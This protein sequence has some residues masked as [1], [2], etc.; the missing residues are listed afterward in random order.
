[1]NK[2]RYLIAFDMDGT[3]LEDKNKTILPLTKKYLKKLSKEGHIIVLASGRPKSEL[4]PYYNELELSSPLV[5]F[6]GIFC[7]NPKDKNFPTIKKTFPKEWA[8]D[9]V[10]QI[11]PNICGNIFI[12][13]DEDIWML[14]EDEKLINT[15]WPHGIHRHM[16]YGDFN[17]TLKE[18]PMTFILYNVKDV[19]KLEKVISKYKDSN[20]RLWFGSKFGEIFFGEISKAY[21]LEKIRKYYNIKKE[22]TICF[23]DY[24]NDIEMVKWAGH[25]VSMLNGIDELKAISKYVT[26]KDNNNEG[27][28]DTLKEIIELN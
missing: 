2:N 25:G 21:C 17:Q 19:E 18:D 24:T 11:Y 5:C 14:Y 13:S 4:I 9:I 1:M 3:L 6:N 15:M 28:V 22:N 12:E 20:L 16:I 27:I 8:L 7:F 23:G 26:K 10:N